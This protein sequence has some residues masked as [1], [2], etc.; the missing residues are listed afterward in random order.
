MV[1]AQPS[2]DG[3]GWNAHMAKTRTTAKETM[4]GKIPGRHA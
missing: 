3:F 2:G 1:N 4:K